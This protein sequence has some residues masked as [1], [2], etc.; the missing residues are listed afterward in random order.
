MALNNT[1]YGRDAVYINNLLLET[2]SGLNGHYFTLSTEGRDVV[3]KDQETGQYEPKV[4][5]VHYAIDGTTAASFKDNLD[6]L[7]HLLNR[8]DADISFNDEYDLFMVGD[9]HNLGLEEK[10]ATWGLGSY[11]IVCEN[12]LKYSKTIGEVTATKTDAGTQTFNINYTGTAPTQ[13]I[14]GVKPGASNTSKVYPYEAN[15]EFINIQNL[16]NGKNLSIGSSYPDNNATVVSN[17]N[18]NQVDIS[19][20]VNTGGWSYGPGTPNITNKSDE[21]ANKGDGLTYKAI[22]P[23]SYDTS[24]SYDENDPKDCNSVVYKTLST[25]MYNF[26]CSYG[27]R[28]WAESVVAGGSIKLTARTTDSNE[29]GV[30]IYKNSLDNLKGKVLY[31]VDGKIMGSDTIDLSQY[32]HS[33]GLTARQSGT[34]SRMGKTYFQDEV[35]NKKRPNTGIVEPKVVGSYIYTPANNN[36]LFS[37]L[38]EVYTFKV[39]DLPVRRFNY[40]RES[41][42]DIG[43]NRLNIG[44]KSN[45]IASAYGNLELQVTGIDIISLTSPTL[46]DNWGIL[47]AG[48]EFRINPANLDLYRN[49]QNSVGEGLYCP[50]YVGLY[51]SEN[52]LVIE[53]GNT[54]N[55]KCIYYNKTS[56]NDPE[57]KIRYNTVY[58]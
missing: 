30:V 52:T 1:N 50:E 44:F 16:I 9:I 24:G 56:G 5:T 32:S 29:T 37:K 58:I 35:V 45:M 19:D 39:A 33:L 22:Y 27:V 13:P 25:N 7:Q 57:I 11:E 23:Y 34:V 54:T 40:V 47:S 46:L 17:I 36:V 28:M 6:Y 18:F 41:G 10:H 8:K 31:Y 21:Y 14:V 2:R 43:Y 53:P 42:T 12:P 48:N 55:F 3:T 38:G 15:L 26:I 49:M 20:L 51:N 4:I